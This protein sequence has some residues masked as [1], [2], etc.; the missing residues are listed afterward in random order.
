MLMN[1]IFFSLFFFVFAADSSDP[2]IV[3][4]AGFKEAIFD[5]GTIQ[6]LL[7]RSN[8]DGVRFYNTLQ[9]GKVGLMAVSISNGADMNSGFFPRKPYVVAKGI[10]NDRVIVDKISE[11]SARDLC[12]AVHNSSYMQ[13]SADFSKSDI[14]NLLSQ[15]NTNALRVKPSK[16]D[17]GHL[18]MELEAVHFEGGQVNDVGQGEMFEMTSTHPCPPICGVLEGYVFRPL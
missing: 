7:D 3:Q 10:D 9:E 5:A 13:Y 17:Q 8:S 18:S 11:G 2:P 12:E 6:E 4:D 16:T 15:G 14:N 1:T